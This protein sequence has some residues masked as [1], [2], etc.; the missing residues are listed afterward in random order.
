[1]HDGRLTLSFASAFANSFNYT[2]DPATGRIATATDTTTGQV[3]RYSYDAVGNIIGVQVSNPSS[4][5]LGTNDSGNTASTTYTGQGQLLT[6]SGSAGQSLSLSINYN[7]SSLAGITVDVFSPDGTLTPAL[8]ITC[9]SGGTPPTCNGSQ[10]INIA[11]LPENGTYQIV[12]QPQPAYSGSG[13]LSFTLTNR[14]LEALPAI[15]NL[16]LDGT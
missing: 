3:A 6:F 15:L 2:Y 10:V 16:I 13:A 5:T 7:S 1:L 9:P 8:S 4:A 11:A 14:G 12:V